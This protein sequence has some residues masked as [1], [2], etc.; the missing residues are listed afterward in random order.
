MELNGN[1]V[2]STNDLMTGLEGFSEGDT[3]KVTVWRPAEVTDASTGNI[4]R[5]G[6]YVEN[7]EVSL[8]VLDGVA[9]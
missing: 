2:S 6:E 7:I 3:V 4:S 9:Q 5:D 8:A 1:V